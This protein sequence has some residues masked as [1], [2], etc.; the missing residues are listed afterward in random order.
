MSRIDSFLPFMQLRR[1]VS[2]LLDGFNAAS[3][4]AREFP[5]V[6]IWEDADS[7]YAEAEIPG[8]AQSELE[9]FTIGDELTLRGK[10]E[11]MQ[12]KGVTFH[13]RER[14][15]GQFERVVRLPADVDA[16]QVAARLNNGVLTITMP[17]AA[18]AKPRKIQVTAG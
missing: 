9:V 10:R 8:V 2:Q 14:G 12:G 16:D 6:N 18:Q 7:F 5:A 4:G 11:P 17:K 3:P 1:E 15:M 13:R